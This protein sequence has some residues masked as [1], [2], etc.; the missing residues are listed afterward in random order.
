[1]AVRTVI[2]TTSPT[3]GQVTLSGLSLASVAT[4]LD[5]VS[6][7]EAVTPAGLAGTM[8]AARAT[9]AEAFDGTSTV[10]VL[11]PAN[12]AFIRSAELAK[13]KS[14]NTSAENYAAIMAAIEATTGTANPVTNTRTCVRGVEIPS[15]VWL[16]NAPITIRSVLGFHLWGAGHCEIRA[17]ADM[18]A[19]FDINGAAYSS[20]ESL[21]LTGS[22]G[23]EVDNAFYTYFH[24]TGAQ[25]TNTANHYVDLT[26][27]NLDFVTGVRIGKTG[28]GAVQVDGDLWE[29]IVVSGAWTTGETS[30]YQTAIHAGTGTVGNNLTHFFNHIRIQLTRYG[31]DNDNTQ[32]KVDGAGFDGGEVAILPGTTG[33]STYNGLRCESHERLLVTD[34]TSAA[35]MITLKDVLYNAADLNAD[36]FWLKF[37]MG[38]TMTMENVAV[39]GVPTGIP[40]LIRVEPGGTT[41]NRLLIRGLAMQ[42]TD[43]PFYLD[44]LFSVAGNGTWKVEGY[45]RQTSGSS[46]TAMADGYGPVLNAQTGTTY[47]FV[48]NDQYK[49]VKGTNAGAITHTIPLDASLR[50]P[51]G[52]K[53]KSWQGGAGAITHAIGGGGTLTGTVTTPAQYSTVEATKVAANAWDCKVTS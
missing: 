14:G 32:V 38:G 45:A 24:S 36:G 34:S 42:G 35:P 7:T 52:T 51:V 18:A 44:D 39:Q 1:M 46:A 41:H 53:L 4:T 49:T 27:R 17:D 31:I 37:L 11:T 3:T 28:I 12:W 22:S 10:K 20:F 33:F 19:I 26:I 16:I 6:D 2:A 47:T 30:R 48:S 13:C 40:P 43:A 29:H 23:V 9:N 5:G 8:T 21:T 25:R 15:G 50:F